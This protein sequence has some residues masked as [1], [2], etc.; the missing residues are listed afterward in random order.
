MFHKGIRRGKKVRASVQVAIPPR[1]GAVV[2]VVCGF[3]VLAAP[4]GAASSAGTDPVLAWGANSDGQLGN[5][6]TSSGSN[7]PVTVKLPKGTKAR[8]V[9]AGTAHSLALTSTGA[10][11]AWGVNINGQLG[12]GSTS[13][14]SHIPVTVMLPPGNKA[15]AIGSGPGAEHSLAIVH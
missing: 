7:V 1:A 4:G 3:F 13:P 10:V 12:D 11:L 6:S 14:N 2:L 5:G 9:A 8:R 15:T